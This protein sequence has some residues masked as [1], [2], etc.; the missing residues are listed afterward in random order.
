MKRKEFSI[1]FA[2]FYKQQDCREF[3]QLFDDSLL[4]DFS[5]QGCSDG[6]KKE[7]LYNE[8]GFLSFLKLYL[9]WNFSTGARKTPT[10]AILPCVLNLS[11]VFTDS[12]DQKEEE[13]VEDYLKHAI[14]EDLRGYQA[15]SHKSHLEDSDELG[16]MNQFLIWNK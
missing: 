1:I 15:E 6:S 14:N 3:F 16:V 4:V 5:Q 8:K 7:L 9:E 10:I 12:S 11:I 13:R 2:K